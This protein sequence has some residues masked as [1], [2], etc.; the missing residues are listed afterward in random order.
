M[1]LFINVS[2]YAADYDTDGIDDAIDICPQF[3]DPSQGD[4]D[5]DGIGDACDNNGQMLLHTIAGNG[6]DWYRSEDEGIDAKKAYLNKPSSVVADQDGTIYI[7]DTENHRIRRIN[8]EATPK[9][10]TYVGTG[11]DNFNGDTGLA[12]EINLKSPSSIVLDSEG[13]LYIVDQ[14]HRVLKVSQDGIVSR[15]AGRGNGLSGFTG[16]TGAASKA[17]L[18]DP[19]DL[20]ID[21]VGNI[22]IADTHNYLIRKVSSDGQIST[23]AG[24]GDY[25]N[26]VNLLE[27]GRPATEVALFSPKQVAV[28]GEGNVYFVNSLDAIRKVNRSGIINTIAGGY[29]NE[30]KAD[31]IHALDADLGWVGGISVD[32]E[33]SIYIASRADNVIRKISTDGI[34]NTIVGTGEWKRSPQVFD[35]GYYDGPPLEANLSSPRD[36]WVGSNGYLYIA[37]TTNNLIRRVDDL[38]YDLDGDLIAQFRDNCPHSKNTDQI[39]SN[40]DGFGDFCD[41]DFD[42]IFTNSNGFYTGYDDNCPYVTNVEQTDTDRDGQGDACDSTP[43]GGDFDGDG[44]A[45]FVDNCPYASNIDQSD[46]DSDGLGNECD[47]YNDTDEDGDGIVYSKEEEFGTD[48]L[49][50]DTDNDGVDDFNELLLG[51]DPLLDVPSDR[52]NDGVQDTLDLCIS[53]YDPGQEDSDNDG[54]GDACD[55][56]GVDSVVVRFAGKPG[57]PPGPGEPSGDGGPA[58]E[59]IFN[60]YA[61]AISFDSADNLYVAEHGVNSPTDDRLRGRIR[62]ITSNII[63]TVAGTGYYDNSDGTGD[64]GEAI[65]AELYAPKDIAFDKNDNL[66]ILDSERGPGRIRKVSGDG[67]ISTYLGGGTQ[68]IYGEPIAA[69]DIDVRAYSLTFDPHDNLHFV[70]SAFVYKVSNDKTVSTVAG[71][72]SSSGYMPDGGLANSSPV[73]GIPRTAIDSK[74]NIYIVET[75]LHRIRKITPDGFISTFAGTGIAGFS[76]DG[77]YASAA[78]FDHPSE[79]EI[80]SQDN[81]YIVDLRNDRIRKITPFG[82]ISTLIGPTAQVI[83]PITGTLIS[84]IQNTSLFLDLALDSKDNLYFLNSSDKRIYKVVDFLSDDDGDT[85]A[86]FKD[87]CPIPTTQIKLT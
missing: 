70:E 18:D 21:S 11:E 84:S 85:I 54:I 62:K 87:N 14:H 20:A 73:R 37:D 47:G 79:I 32:D 15:F 77:G 1:F 61:N 13:N 10:E 22:Y 55:T 24:T 28:D 12:T 35:V 71:S 81:I 52:D 42:G 75:D 59:A 33:G 44:L 40:N 39:D 69:N 72:S 78:Q 63:S 64:G 82:I 76:G 53:L 38:L 7:A 57:I 30:D 34:I 46:L 16:H 31:G 74:G 3:Y 27:D 29:Y 80:D 5:N 67:G 19:S 86:F 43:L 17:S 8:T 65:N 49:K 60:Y 83:N 26:D 9:I 36:I 66:Y 6:Y 25:L 2:A 50:S 23:V 41:P 4:S 68:R 58:T 56:N 51:L 45:D 48:P